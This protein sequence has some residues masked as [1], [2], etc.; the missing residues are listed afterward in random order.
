L[1]KEQAGLEFSDKNPATSFPVEVGVGELVT[2]VQQGETE[3]LG[4]LYD[5]YAGRVYAFLLRAVEPGLAE[6][7][8]QDV[9]VALWQKAGQFDPARGSFNAWFFTLVRHRLY[10][11]L[12]RYQKRRAENSLSAPGIGT[13]SH[14]LSDGKHNPE[15]QILQLF[16]DEEVR[17]AL[18]HLPPEQRQT[19]LMT[20]FG[21]FSQRELAEQLNL[22]VSTIKGRARLGLQRL[23]QLLPEQI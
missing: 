23:R 11:A 4:E 21:G 12:P 9:F 6:E 1:L 5:R 10:D 8:L 7:L 3:A 17:Q 15:E 22:P 19:I 20:Y 14:E 16:R 18:Q 13:I 2:R